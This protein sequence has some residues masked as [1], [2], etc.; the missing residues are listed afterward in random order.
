MQCL[1]SSFYFSAA[2]TFLTRYIR[3]TVA[4]LLVIVIVV[5]V[6]IFINKQSGSKKRSIDARSFKLTDEHKLNDRTFEQARAILRWTPRRTARRYTGI[7]F[8]DGDGRPG[9]SVTF[10]DHGTAAR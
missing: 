3:F 7:I 6:Y 2:Q 1:S 9:E 10:E 8:A 5:V 4:V